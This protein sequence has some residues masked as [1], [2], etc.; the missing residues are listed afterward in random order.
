VVLAAMESARQ[1]MLATIALIPEAE[2]ES[3]LVCGVWT[4]KDVLG[5]VADWEWYGVERWRPEQSNRSLQV[6]YPGTIQEWNDLHAAARKDD[7]W[8][9]VWVDFVNARAALQQIVEGLDEEELGRTVPAPWNP[10]D[11]NYRWILTW[12]HHEREH[13][14]DLRLVLDLPDFPERLTHV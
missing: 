1:E 3:R 14:A 12:I 13:A 4:L 10:N 6:P 9:R 5:H 8:E 11:S 7:S 2:R